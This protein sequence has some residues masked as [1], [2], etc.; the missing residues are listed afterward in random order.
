MNSVIVFEVSQ[1][2]D[3]GFVAECLTEDIFTQGDSWEE[4]RVNVNEAVKGYYFDQ[5]SCPQVKL[6]LLKEEMLVIQ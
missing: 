5:P 6:H 3:G 1:E 2:E 4:L